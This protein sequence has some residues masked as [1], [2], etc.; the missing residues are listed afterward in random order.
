MK[1][2]K[3]LSSVFLFL[4]VLL[5]A[6]ACTEDDNSSGSGGGQSGVI[7]ESYLLGTWV[8]PGDAG[9]D[10][11]TFKKGGVGE[12]SFTFEGE[13]ILETFTYVYNAKS[14]ELILKYDDGVDVFYIENHTENTITF[15]YE[16]SDGIIEQS[17][18]YRQG[19]ST[20]EE[21]L[22]EQL[23]GTWIF[24][25][26]DPSDYTYV[27]FKTEG[28]GEI[29]YY[30]SYGMESEY[31]TYTVNESERTVYA[32]FG[33]EVSVI[34]VFDITDN[35]A[36]VSI[37]ENGGTPENVVLKRSNDTDG[38]GSVEDGNPF[39][40]KWVYKGSE[41][42]TYLNFY[43]NGQGSIIDAGTPEEMFT[44]TY[45]PAT[46]TAS[47]AFHDGGR[48]KLTL[49]KQYDASLI[50]VRFEEEGSSDTGEE[51]LL[52]LVER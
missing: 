13:T 40:G 14:K 34:K 29:R 7:T 48:A 47:I 15:S 44:Y 11:F 37:S 49:L 32:Y 45:N 4:L 22:G 28:Q 2:L 39:L 52:E 12:W 43:R 27:I 10:Y 6:G 3:N 35:S 5:F 1:T 9:D 31:F 41:L 36:K 16:I 50:L 46:Q 20:S 23:I 42:K 21:T 19:G 33:D 17:V 18:L 30:D 38:P 26:D 8:Y 25:E 24:T 51:Y